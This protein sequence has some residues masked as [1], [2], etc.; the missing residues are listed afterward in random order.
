[1]GS[2][3]VQDRKIR[4]RKVALLQEYKSSVGCGCGEKDPR[5]L[6]FHHVDP[7]MKHKRLKIDRTNVRGSRWIDLSYESIVREIGFCVVLCANCHRKEEWELAVCAGYEKH[8]P[9]YQRA[10][11]A[12]GLS[13]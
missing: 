5:A 11:I 3:L 4:R 7:S 2:T 8:S 6:D 9:K 12:L 1:M 13:T 10:R